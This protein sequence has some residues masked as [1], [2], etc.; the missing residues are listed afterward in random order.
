MVIDVGLYKNAINA[1]GNYLLWIEVNPFTV[2]FIGKILDIEK[3]DFVVLI[4]D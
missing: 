4:G 3:P 2:K 1:H